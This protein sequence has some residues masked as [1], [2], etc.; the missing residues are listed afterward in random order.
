MK[1]FIIYWTDSYTDVWW[2][3]SKVKNHVCYDI[4]LFNK[5][6]YWKIIDNSIVTIN[7]EIVLIIKKNSI[8]IDVLLND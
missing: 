3:N 1:I 7:N 5:Q 2:I 8:I 4:N 6:S